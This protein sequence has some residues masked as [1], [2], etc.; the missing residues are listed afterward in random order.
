MSLRDNPTNTVSGSP[1]SIEIRDRCDDPFSLT[2]P[3]LTFTDL[4]YTIGDPAQVHFLDPGFSVDPTTC[5]LNV[6]ESLEGPPEVH[7]VSNFISAFAIPSL[8]VNY[9]ADLNPV[10]IYTATI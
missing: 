8:T 4:V 9:S 1:F 3:T 10:G 5:N 6:V 2:A 7:A